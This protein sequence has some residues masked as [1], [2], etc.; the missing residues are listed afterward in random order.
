MICDAMWIS[1]VQG[2]GCKVDLLSGIWG[3]SASQEN[4]AIYAV[5]CKFYPCVDKDKN[6]LWQTLGLQRLFTEMH[7]AK[8]SKLSFKHLILLL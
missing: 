7:T 8:N 5:L 1:L 4:S 6:G 3:S 2:S